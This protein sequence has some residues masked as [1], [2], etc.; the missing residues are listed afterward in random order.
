MKIEV[1]GI[2][3]GG[4]NIVAELVQELESNEETSG[5]R[6]TSEI[7]YSTIDTSRNN[8][9]HNDKVKTTIIKDSGLSNE[10]LRGSGGNQKENVVHIKRGVQE[11]I[12]LNDLHKDDKTLYI[13]IFTV[14]GGTGSVGGVMLV[15]HLKANGCNVMPVVIAD[16]SN[17]NY[18]I[19]SIKTFERINTI[20]NNH[21]SLCAVVLNNK[22]YVN[23]NIGINKHD[24]INETIVSKIEALSVFTSGV[25]RDIDDKDM[26]YF[27]APHEY[28]DIEI[29][30]GL[31]RVLI[32]ELK[33]SDY[34]GV[35]NGIIARTL[36]STESKGSETSPCSNASTLKH[37]KEGYSESSIIT[38]H[39]DVILLDDLDEFYE[40]MVKDRS[41]FKKI[42]K[43][44]IPSSDDVDSF[45]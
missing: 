22:D 23:E 3:G 11:F 7:N 42:E 12:E 41:A 37:F 45:L 40:S 19:S 20:A 18:T 9:N 14:S 17:E 32:G 27:F 31:Y 36:Y 28:G 34:N 13:V 2:G 16:T 5:N 15:N 21:G 29:P 35:E 44:V 1:I 6:L 39:I 10:E 30:N 26:E 24:I 25:N 33:N 8:I 43:K 4:S 38:S